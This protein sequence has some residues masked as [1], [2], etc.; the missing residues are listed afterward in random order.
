M[1]NEDPKSNESHQV[2]LFFDV[3]PE[4]AG[5]TPGAEIRQIKTTSVFP[6]P[7]PPPA[8]PPKYAQPPEPDQSPASVPGNGSKPRVG[9]KLSMPKFN[10]KILAV[11][12]VIALLAVGSYFAYRYF[13]KKGESTETANSQAQVQKPPQQ[14][15]PVEWLKK[16]FGSDT[17]DITV[18]GP[19]ADPDKDGLKNTKEL[20]Y[21]TSPL[22]ADSDFDGLADS[23]EVQIYNSDPLVSDTDGDGFEDGV[24]VRNG[25]SPTASSQ[26]PMSNME[27]TVFSDN[28]SAFGL[29]EPTKTFLT[30][31]TYKAVFDGGVTSTPAFVLSIPNGWT[32]ESKPE[33]ITLKSVDQKSVI[34][35]GQFAAVTATDS[36]LQTILKSTVDTVSADVQKI[37]K[38]LQKIGQ[39]SLNLDENQTLSQIQG[40]EG[41]H[42]LRA[43][44]LKNSRVY[45]VYFSAPE[46]QWSKNQFLAQVVIN[47]VR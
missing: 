8:A 37:S 9:F 35:L 32:S 16:Y 18:C 1:P 17:C 30:L 7:P 24:E 31:V 27:K 25:Y 13:A 39:L 26:S 3:M 5:K 43:I 2:K 6:L 38:S 28:I 46:S 44:F 14:P 47:S 22:N 36:D 20:Q 21:S 33:A 34:Y 45:Q 40:Q 12:G 15:L 29:H 4:A 41:T 23:D 42:V 19:D 11:I 10:I